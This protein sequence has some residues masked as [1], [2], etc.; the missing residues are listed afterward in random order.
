[1]SWRGIKGGVEAAKQKHSVVMCP[2]SH[3]YFI[4]YQS[5]DVENEPFARGGFLPLEKVYSY[6]PIPEELTDEESRLILGAQGC[7][8]TEYIG[9]DKKMEYMLFP[10]IC[11]LAEVVWSPKEQKDFRNFGK[12]MELEY[13][14][15][16]LYKVNYKD[17]RK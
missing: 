7:V 8:W 9:S 6:E 2:S 11:A 1:M 17:Y 13:Q 15:M 10:R 3:L 16:D 12:R 5:K 4:Y 14:R